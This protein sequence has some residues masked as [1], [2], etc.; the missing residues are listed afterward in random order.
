MRRQGTGMVETANR[1]G[2]RQAK[3]PIAP[4]NALKSNPRTL[5]RPGVGARVATF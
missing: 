2:R 1:R 5:E 3:A 4:M